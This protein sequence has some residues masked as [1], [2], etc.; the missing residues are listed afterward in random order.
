MGMRQKHLFNGAKLGWM[1]IPQHA[2]VVLTEPVHL[3]RWVAY[4]F[5]IPRAID[6]VVSVIQYAPQQCKNAVEIKTV[7]GPY[8]VAL[9]RTSVVAGPVNGI[10]VA[11][12]ICATPPGIPADA[13]ILLYLVN[14]AFYDSAVQVFNTRAYVESPAYR[15]PAMRILSE[16]WPE[17]KKYEAR[18]NTIKVGPGYDLVDVLRTPELLKAVARWAQGYFTREIVQILVQA[19]L[20]K[21]IPLKIVD[22]RKDVEV[23][24]IERH[25]PSAL[26]VKA[27]LALGHLWPAELLRWAEDWQDA[28]LP[29]IQAMF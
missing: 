12:Q 29:T 25:R 1:V 21:Q 23:R 7:Y 15:L 24:I 6:L 8:A 20:V 19:E 13:S 10:P 5:G 2:P 22:E 26:G 14:P 9:T 17:L 11:L 16:K 3:P 28:I 4:M 18:D 27:L